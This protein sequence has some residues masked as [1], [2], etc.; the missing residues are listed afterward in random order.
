MNP[1]IL[2]PK[3]TVR[4]PWKFGDRGD[5]YIFLSY[6][7]VAEVKVLWRRTE[8]MPWWSGGY[9]ARPECKRLG[10]DPPLRHT[11]FFHQNP[12]LHLASN[13]GLTDLFVWSKHEDTLSPEGGEC[14]G[15]L[16]RCLGGLAVMTLAR[17]AR[18]RGSI[19]RWGTLN[20]SVRTHC[21]ST[22]FFSRIQYSLFQ[23]KSTDLQVIQRHSLVR[24]IYTA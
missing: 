5:A 10:F 4:T 6:E 22:N 7:N 2:P 24:N 9:D 1:F 15:K 14:D 17:N 12:L 16:N 3:L 21:Y 18:D 11:E 13:V 23:I 8:Q 20:F 19:P